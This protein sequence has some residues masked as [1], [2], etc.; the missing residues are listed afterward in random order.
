MSNR[1]KFF[2]LTVFL[3]VL[4]VMLAFSPVYTRAATLNCSTCTTLEQLYDCIKDQM[5]LRDDGYTQ[6]TA[7]QLTDLRT[8]MGQMLDGQTGITLP[9]SI[10]TI[11]AFSR[12]T[13]TG[14]SRTYSVLMEVEDGNNDGM[15]D[16]GFGTFIVYNEA[17]KELN[18]AASHPAYDLTTGEECIRIFKYTGARA[19]S[20][21]GTHRYASST[22]S[23]CQSSYKISDGAHNADLMFFGATQELLDYYGS[24]PWFQIQY[25]GMA[26]DSC[27]CDVL[28]SHGERLDTPLPADIIYTFQSNV[29]SYN[30]SWDVDVDGATSCTLDGG[31]NT[32]GRLISGV[33]ASQVCGT[34]PSSR[35]EQFIHIEQISDCRTA[36]DWIDAV[37]DTFGSG[38]PPDDPGNLSVFASACD[39]ADL[40]WIDNSSDESMFRIERSI[41]GSDFSEIDT[42]AADTTSYNDTTVAESTTYWY[43]VRA[44]NSFGLSGYSN[45]DS[46]STPACPPVPPA[47]PSDLTGAV[48]KYSVDLSW[49]DNS[50]NETGFKIYRGDSPTTLQ[51]IDTVA[52]DTTS[53]LDE[54]L[55]RKTYYYYKVCAY[56]AYGENCTAVLEKKTK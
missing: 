8:V 24:N 5:R 10:S 39:Q 21:N 18:I 12:F 36:T 13:D 6:P 41:N 38:L 51:L 26:T 15:V 16:K 42:V 22:T 29:L 19:F 55:I 3:L 44:S 34:A 50:D 30:P 52:A 11:M 53:Y 45:T 40:S 32:S 9:A 48:A 27:S 28:M 56:N 31:S 25:H 47:A 7:Q 17:D 54:G 49:T 2:T 4:G 20:A 33:A 1:N 43:K 14:N 35:S 37:N 23:P 46:D